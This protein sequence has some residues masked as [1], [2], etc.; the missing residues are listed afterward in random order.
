[1]AILEKAAGQGHAYAM[2]ALGSFHGKRKEYEQAVK[3]YSKG[4]EAG[5]PK[6]MVNLGGLLDKGQGVE[7]P[8]CVAAAG[9]Y[10]PAADAGNGSAA[11]NLSNFYTVGRGRD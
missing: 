11:N 3:W 7:A 6:A 9:W 8:D 5:L 10:R 2:F 1:M 4:A